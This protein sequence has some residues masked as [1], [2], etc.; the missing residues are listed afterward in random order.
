MSPTPSERQITVVLQEIRRKQTEQGG[1]CCKNYEGS[2]GAESVPSHERFLGYHS[3]DLGGQCDLAL[4]IS[5]YV[6]IFLGPLDQGSA[7]VIPAR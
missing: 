3:K 4:H 2:N 1:L 6:T 5:L 7:G